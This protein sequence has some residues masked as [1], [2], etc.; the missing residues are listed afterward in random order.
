MFTIPI[1]DIQHAMFSDSNEI[2]LEASEIG[3]KPGEW[4]DHIILMKGQNGILF[5]KSS[6]YLSISECTVYRSKG[7][8]TEL[9]ILN[10]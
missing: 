5:Q 3:L 9:H 8:K 7:L 10:D 6:H 1:E 4:P 2:V